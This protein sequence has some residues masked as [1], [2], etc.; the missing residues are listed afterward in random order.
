MTLAPAWLAHH[1]SHGS[2]AFQ[3][4]QVSREARSA[5]PFLTDEALGR[6]DPVLVSRFDAMPLAPPPSPLHFIFHS[7]FCCSTL[8]A[9]ALDLPGVASTLKEPVILNDLIGWRHGG[10]AA[11]RLPAVLNDTIRL[12]ARPFQN[13]EAMVVKPSNLINELGNDILGAAG[14][15]RAIFME[16][17]IDE[18]VASI[19]TK[20]LE[21]RIWVRTL[22]MR[23]LKG[24]MINLG[25]TTED[26]FMQ[27]DLQVAAVT[28][29]VQHQ[30]FRKLSAKFTGRIL[31]L[32]SDTLLDDPHRA[33]TTV[34]D[35]FRLEIQ[36]DVLA[37]IVETIF[38]RNAKD[39]SS[40]GA[41]QRRLGFD[42][43]MATYGEEV[44]KVVTWAG[45]VARNAG[46]DDV[47]NLASSTGG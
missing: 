4:I 9:T 47:G 40:Y 24:Q 3:F 8:L 41:A 29:L 25:F 21:G 12:L 33:M 7:A 15:A 28:W 6:R 43:A 45:A 22:L 14:D 23:Q 36:P 30:L 42:R 39:S 13:G 17:P 20:G 44:S 27:T 37:S 35:H 5:A 26:L 2:D 10:S 18:F 19:A 31:W 32:R 11:A 34:A 16:A 1:Y 38:S 46:F